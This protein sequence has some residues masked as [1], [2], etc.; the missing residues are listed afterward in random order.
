MDSEASADAWLA[1]RCTAEVLA[2][3]PFTPLPVLGIPGWWSGNENFSF[4]DDSLVFRPRKTT[5]PITTTT[6]AGP[7]RS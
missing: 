2:G 1:R 4:Y 6:S 5:E 3:K 7:A